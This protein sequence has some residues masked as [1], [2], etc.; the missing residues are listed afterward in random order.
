MPTV[1]MKRPE[2]H[3]KEDVNIILENVQLRSDLAA[4]EERYLQMEKEVLSLRAEVERLQGE[5][6]QAQAAQAF[7]HAAA[8]VQAA[9]VQ[10]A[11]V[12]D[13]LAAAQAQAADAFQAVYNQMPPAS[14]AV[15]AADQAKSG[16]QSMYKYVRQASDALVSPANDSAVAQQPSSSSSSA[17]NPQVGAC[18]QPML[19]SAE[20]HV[21]VAK[22]EWARLGQVCLERVALQKD[23]WQRHAQSEALVAALDIERNCSRELRNAY[24]F[25]SAKCAALEG[26]ARNGLGLVARQPSAVMCVASLSPA[27]PAGRLGTMHALPVS[28]KAVPFQAG[29]DCGTMPMGSVHM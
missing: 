18:A 9:Q 21:L 4:S 19:K 24:H 15:A 5:L 27:Q 1:I 11:Q 2:N 25:V 10:A 6:P 22:S 20:D 29:G 8:Q 7:E 28:G 12:V 3:V 26:D 13:Q 17:A 16:A 23:V 14:H